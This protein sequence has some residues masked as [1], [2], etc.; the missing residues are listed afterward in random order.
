MRPEQ[1]EEP[2]DPSIACAN[3]A[4]VIAE[5]YCPEA[6]A[7]GADC[8]WYHGIWPYYRALGLGGSAFTHRAVLSPTLRQLASTGD[9]RRVLISGAADYATLA[10]V[11]GEY[12][13]EHSLPECTVVDVCETPLALC[14]WYAGL[15][16]ITIETIAASI[17]DANPE[18]QFDLIIT[19]SFLG[20]FD[21]PA[22]FR[23]ARKWSSLLR[24]G[25]KVFLLNRLRKDA[26][27]SPVRFSDAQARDYLGLVAQESQRGR[28]GLVVDEAYVMR[29][30]MEYVRNIAMFPVRSTDELRPVFESAGF[31]LDRL[32]SIQLAPV[33]GRAAPGLTVAGFPDYL[34]LLATKGAG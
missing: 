30:T 22:R 7:R 23:L 16:S 12:E 1:A 26:G 14:R 27:E 21:P 11:L 19:H 2:D 10:V 18:R 8:L 33:A 25:G 32:Q 15:R 20:Y 9:F 29:A 4:R 3:I 5:K 6:A 28:P 17:L 24:A 31:A 13:A 34:E